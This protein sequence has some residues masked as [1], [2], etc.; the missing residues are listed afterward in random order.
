MK[1]IDCT[2]IGM[3]LCSM[4]LAGCAGESSQDD[5]VAPSN[6]TS[7]QAERNIVPA[8]SSS[9]TIATKEE[10]Q[11]A[12][13]KNDAPKDEKPA[14]PSPIAFNLCATGLPDETEMFK[15]DPIFADVNQDGHLDL[16]AIA[17]LGEGPRVWLGDGAGN[18]TESSNGLKRTNSQQS[19][20]GG[21]RFVDINN[22]NNLDLVVGDHC[23][24]V[25]VYLGDGDG[26][27]NM[28]TE[29]LYPED[30]IPVGAYQAK[31]VGVE[32]VAV[33]DVNKDG[34][35]DILAGS[36]DE[37]GVRL[38]LGDGTG[39]NWER[40]DGILPEKGW[41]VRVEL[42][43]MNKDGWLDAV[44]S[45]SEGPRVYLNDEGK[46]WKMGSGNM[47]T[48]MMG[49]IFHGLAIGDINEDGR[50]DV[51]VA[52]W[53]DGPEVYLQQNDG[54][55]QKTPDVFPQ[56]LG[57]SV[58]IDLG[59][60]DGDGHLD[61]VVTGR[62]S[63]DPGFVRGVYALLGD[64]AGNWRFLENSGLPTTGMA[65]NSGCSLADINDDGT[66]DVAVCSG[67]IVET[68]PFGPQEPD[69]ALKL[70]V[71]CNTPKHQSVEAS[72]E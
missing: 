68:V 62:L 28:V 11:I 27:W 50:D 25:F 29:G 40:R 6:E 34:F 69:F 3:L 49:G 1:S 42:H 55:W 12:V 48:P 30:V 52:N 21:M 57:G 53:I 31:Y 58:G 71:W 54:S 20:G 51:C 10:T 61:I 43:D 59:D 33:G 18:W 36:A 24:G 16:G 70:L 13:E 44:C 5:A 45:Y 39:K 32:S 23:A 2:I 19:C 17:R 67:L 64:G 41:A 22:D 63:Q 47:P 46:T 38:Y 56:M 37:S 7:A 4:T 66:L 15:C 26:N 9:E 65:A 60:L 14:K 35:I 8:S 72:E